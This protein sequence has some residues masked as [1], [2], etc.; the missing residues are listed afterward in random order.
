MTAPVLIAWGSPTVVDIDGEGDYA[1]AHLFELIA[2]ASGFH[3][4]SVLHGMV[5]CPCDVLSPLDGS[6]EMIEFRILPTAEPELYSMGDT[7]PE[8]L[9]PYKVDVLE[10]YRL[11]DGA[12]D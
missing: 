5:A 3:S 7:E 4:Q 9:A 1:Y 12:V 6:C 11:Q 8:Y 10:S 2:G